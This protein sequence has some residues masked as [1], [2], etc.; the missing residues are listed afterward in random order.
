MSVRIRPDFAGPECHNVDAHDGIRH[1]LAERKQ[2]L[3]DAHGFVYD[4]TPMADSTDEEIID[5]LLPG[6][7]VDEHLLARIQELRA[8]VERTGIGMRAWKIRAETAEA[9]VER[10]RAVADAARKM[11]R[12][13]R[14]AFG[15]R[16]WVEMAN[17]LD[18]LDA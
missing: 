16:L 3:V 12:W 11:E 18:A 6:E 10:L 7:G 15:H 1:T 4:E 17:A 13:D 2:H 5:M 8:E 9:E 14:D